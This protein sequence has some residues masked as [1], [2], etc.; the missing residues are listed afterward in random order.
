KEFTRVHNEKILSNIKELA[1]TDCEI[2]FRMPMIKDVNCDDEN[3]KK[4]AEFMNSL[5]GKRNKINLLPYHKVAE[6]KLVKLGKA[7]DFIEFDSPND[8]DISKVISLFNYY[9]I[10]ASIGG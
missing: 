1:K 8:D 3:I 7:D 10:N 4:T 2:I 5:K 6:N 9:G